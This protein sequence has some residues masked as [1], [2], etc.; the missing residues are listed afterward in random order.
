MKKNEKNKNYSHHTKRESVPFYYKNAIQSYESMLC[1]DCIMHVTYSYQP[2]SAFQ[3]YI[4]PL[5]FKLNLNL[6]SVRIYNHDCCQL[7]PS[8][9]YYL[10]NTPHDYY[11]DRYELCVLY[12]LEFNFLNTLDVDSK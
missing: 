12:E 8:F 7:Q 3:M 5:Q 2:F 6:F 11:R 9:M 10:N 4:L 1:A